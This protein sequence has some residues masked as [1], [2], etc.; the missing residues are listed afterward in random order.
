MKYVRMIEHIVHVL[1]KIDLSSYI[2]RWNMQ[3]SQILQIKVEN[4]GHF[5]DAIPLLLKNK[6]I[7][8]HKNLSRGLKETFRNLSSKLIEF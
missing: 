2:V 4:P 3:M 5:W 8:L 7:W 6:Q 1:F